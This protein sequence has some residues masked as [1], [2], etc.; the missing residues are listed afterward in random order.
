LVAEIDLD[1]ARGRPTAGLGQ[2][3]AGNRI[4]AEVLAAESG[5]L[6]RQLRRD[7]PSLGGRQRRL[8]RL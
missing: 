3:G 7:R 8:R 5:G 2:Q 1:Q 4:T 6:G